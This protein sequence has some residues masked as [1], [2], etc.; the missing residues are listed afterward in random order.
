MQYKAYPQDLTWLARLTTHILVQMGC[1]RCRLAL[2]L[3]EF[4]RQDIIRHTGIASERIRVTPLAADAAFGRPIP[5]REQHV[6]RLLGHDAPYFL[7]VGN[8]YPHKQ[9]HV[10]VEAFGRVMAD[11][12]HRLVLVSKPRLGEHELHHAIRSLPD[13]NRVTRLQRVSNQDLI[14][15]Y[16]SA[17]A[18][19][20]PS[21]YEGFGLP[22]VEAM[23]AGT[24]VIASRRASIPEVGGTAAVYADPPTPALFAERILSVL[25]W[26]PTERA[27]HIEQGRKQAGNFTW[28]RT[29]TLT[30]RAVVEAT[31]GGGI[32]EDVGDMPTTARKGASAFS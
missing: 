32:E 13:P 17:D 15:L 3:S 4:A 6:S 11:I 10:A 18:F 24:P 31:H 23:L 20:M 8:S 19:L 27:Q 1:R 22:V 28:D 29:A 30:Y 26:S 14:A 16:Q 25:A 21:L 5:D 9:M 2:T 12:Q 7:A